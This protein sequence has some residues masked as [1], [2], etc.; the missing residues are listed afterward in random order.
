MKIFA[1][2]LCL[3]FIAK[4]QAAQYDI[5]PISYAELMAFF[6]KGID[7]PGQVFHIEAERDDSFL[8]HLFELQGNEVWRELESTVR[9]VFPSEKARDTFVEAFLA[10]FKL[11]D[12]AGGLVKNEKGEYLG[13]LARNR[14]SLPKGGV[15]WREEIEDAAMREVMEETGLEKV[16]LLGPL[17]KTFHT[18]PR[19]RG[20]ICKTTYWFRMN[21]ASDQAITPQTEEGIEAVAWLSP[22]KWRELL[23]DTYPLIRY[24]FQQEFTQSL[25]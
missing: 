4:D 21:A 16:D 6:F 10:R 3:D 8:E 12:A 9:V 25:I 17:P 5:S 7:F 13:I 23:D 14:W 1:L 22:D 24:L 20:W 2:N 19:R 18:F 11:V 15:E